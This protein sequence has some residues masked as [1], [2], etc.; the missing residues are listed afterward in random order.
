MLFEKEIQNN[1][2]QI[3]NYFDSDFQ[4]NDFSLEKFDIFVHPDVIRI[5]L[6][7]LP[8]S[9]KIWFWSIARLMSTG[10]DNVPSE[11]DR[12]SQDIVPPDW[13]VLGFCENSEAEYRLIYRVHDHMDVMIIEIVSIGIHDSNIDKQVQSLDKVLCKPIVP[14]VTSLVLKSTYDQDYNPECL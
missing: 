13:S 10:L 12:K 9:V 14:V 8:E 5:D 6:P 7:S 11:F 4:D 1:I 3:D 2:F